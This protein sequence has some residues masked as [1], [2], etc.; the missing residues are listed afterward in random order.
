MLKNTVHTG[1]ISIWAVFFMKKA[2][3]RIMVC[4][5]AALFVW[6]AFL[7]ADR[8]QLNHGLIRF[9][10][11]ANSDSREDQAIKLKIR[12]AVLASM[13][14]DLRKISDIDTAR[15][16]LREHLP[17]IQLLVDQTLDG[18]GYSGGSAVSLCR[19]RFDVRHYDTFSLPA[20]V[21][22]S[23]KIVIGDGMGKNWWCVSFP[24]L[25]LPATTAD[26]IDAA[27][28]SGFSEPL[29]QTLSRNE[30]YQIRFYF[31]NQLGKLQNILFPESITPCS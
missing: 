15:V 27:V 23:L 31:L 6:C 11:I 13:E 14:E 5:L 8:E 20:G 24:G 16:Y 10:V 22:E 26:F 19:E 28:G 30:D 4:W 3:Y 9:H 21:Y 7:L 17:K 2:M 12:D 1:S 29:V 25:C 18:L